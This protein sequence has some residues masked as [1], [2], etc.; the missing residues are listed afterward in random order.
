[1][2]NARGAI[3]LIVLVCLALSSTRSTAAYRRAVTL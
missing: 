2:V 3:E 1:M